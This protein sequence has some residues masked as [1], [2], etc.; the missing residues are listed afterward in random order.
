MFTG[1]TETGKHVMER[2]AKTLTPVSLELGGKDPMIVLDD[3]D[4]ER[5]SNAALFWSMQNAGQTCIS[6]ERVYVE[7]P[8]YDEFVALVGREGAR[9]AA[10]RPGGFGSVDVGSF[11]N[12]PQVDIVEAHVN[13]AVAKGARVLAGGHRGTGDGHVLSSRPCSPTSTTRWS[14]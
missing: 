2:A 10:G 11:I 5:A 12:P 6:V 8:I 4:L 7:E 1:S 13:D 14:A 3:A 9:A